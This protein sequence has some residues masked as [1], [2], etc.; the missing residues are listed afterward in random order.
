MKVEINNK[1]Q[2]TEIKFPCLMESE[3]GKTVIVATSY[4]DEENIEGFA[5]K[6]PH[7]IHHSI[8]WHKKVFKPF[9][10]SITL[11]ND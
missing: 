11:S 5:L 6:N 10:G 1:E 7:S 4:K 9:N 3:D 8:Y 2:N